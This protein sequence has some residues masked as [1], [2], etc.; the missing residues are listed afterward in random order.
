MKQEKILSEINTLPQEAQQE[1]LD[2]I[3]FLQSRYQTKSKDK[4]GS[5]RSLADE[6]FVGIWRDRVDLTDSNK[7]VREIRS[8]EWD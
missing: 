4:M 5:E 2:F 3:A 1:V 8:N 7:W 6:S